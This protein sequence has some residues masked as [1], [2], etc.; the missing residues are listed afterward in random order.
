MCYF[1]KCDKIQKKEPKVGV[2]EHKWP[3]QSPDLDPSKH[4]WD[5]LEHRFAN[6][7]S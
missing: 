1:V 7:Q 6:P 4:I 2:K 5:E 3:A